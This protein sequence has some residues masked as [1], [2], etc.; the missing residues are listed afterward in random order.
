MSNQVFNIGDLPIELHLMIL[1]YL[2]LLT[3]IRLQQTSSQYRAHPVLFKLR[4][5]FVCQHEEKEE[6]LL[7]VKEYVCYACFSILPKSALTKSN[8]RKARKKPASRYCIKCGVKNKQ[9]HPGNIFN[10]SDGFGAC[11]KLVV[12]I[13]CA[14]VTTN[15]CET[16]KWCQNCIQEGVVTGM[17]RKKEDVTVMRGK[18]GVVAVLRGKTDFSQETLINRCPERPHRIGNQMIEPP[19]VSFSNDQF[20]E[21]EAPPFSARLVNLR[22]AEITW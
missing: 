21:S 4:K 13:M 7:V 14:K 11:Q 10:T 6:R 5:G 3:T 19:R 2:D 16:C 12:C 22:T 8:L 15:F 17:T 1:G 18:T 20:C 9:F